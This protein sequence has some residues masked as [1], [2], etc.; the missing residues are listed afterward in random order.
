MRTL[1]YLSPVLIVIA[2]LVNCGPPRPSP[3]PPWPKGAW[4]RHTIDDS[5][6]GA[7]GVRF[8]DI[9]GDGRL[10]ITTPWE[11]GGQVRV[12]I[13]PGKAGLRD[14]WPAVTVGVVGDPEDSFF[15]DL[16]GDGYLDV[17]SSCEGATRS[18]FVHWSPSDRNRLLDP[19]AWVTEELP[20]ASGVGRWMYAYAT[21]VDGKFG[22]DLVAGSKKEDA[23]LGWFES[24]KNPRDLASWRW[25]P[26]Y[27]AG[28]IM[29]IRPYDMDGDGD[30]DIVATDRK[31]ARRG[32][33]WLEN[34][35]PASVATVAWREHRIG[36]VGDHEAM[37]YTIADLDGDGLEDVLVAVKGGPIQF[38]RRTS[39]SPPA[40]ETH[41]IEMPPNTGSGKAVM[42]ADVDLDGKLDLIIA[43]EH[44][45][46]GK[47]GIFWLSYDREPT[48]SRWTATSISGPDGFINDLI[49]VIDLDGDGDLDVV[50]VEEKGPYLARGYQGSELGVIWYENP[51][52]P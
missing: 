30:L 39:Q 24:P 2:F 3:P 25:H 34:P 33:L 51:T 22:I 17:V 38:H 36:P 16:D 41:E 28:W 44:A 19:D 43:C 45:I 32:A 4:L 40:W 29:T 26:L 11:E 20:A 8:G 5:S 31:G 23:K 14:R 7:D 1:T 18:M 50:T 21:Q 46:D 10:D 15:V 52:R 47:I 9:N 42:V 48:E 27:E 12:Y 49:Q 35:G 37:H 13:N 6:Q